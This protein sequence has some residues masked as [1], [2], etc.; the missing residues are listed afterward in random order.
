MIDYEIFD[1]FYDI[2]NKLQG[3]GTMLKDDIEYFFNDLRFAK[4]KTI[5]GGTYK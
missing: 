5:Y 2:Y 3:D 1:D 4:M